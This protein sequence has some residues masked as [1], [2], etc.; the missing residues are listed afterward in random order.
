MELCPEPLWEE[1]CRADPTCTFYQTPSWLRIAAR[2]DQAEIA[3]LLFRP[4]GEP[5]C[6]PLLKKRRWGSDRYYSA[7]GTYAAT[8]CGKQ[9]GSEALASISRQLGDLNLHLVSSPFT[10]NPV[11]VGKANPS[12]VQV[13]DLTGLDS[14]NPMRDWGEDQRRR[15]R[16][17]QREGV[18]VRPAETPGEWDRYYE[19]YRL[20]LERWGGK[21]TVAYP[22][23]LFGDFRASLA[24]NPAMRLWVAEHQGEIGAGYLTFY[25]N[26]HVVPWHG[27]ADKRFFL[28]GV[29]QMLFHDMIADAIRR[30][31]RVFDLTG[32]GSLAKVEAFK[33]RFGTRTIEFASSRNRVGTARFLGRV[34][35]FLRKLA[36][37]GM[38][39][40]AVL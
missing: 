26:R 16:V 34:G 17:A 28:L 9:L 7:F 27:A 6:L 25:H 21:T 3:P 39:K 32:S 2:N 31:F 1:L 38:G 29:A 15:V 10:H 23:S 37:V 33:S 18:K 24:D 20:S 30:G 19:L 40:S 4:G 12:R 36:A 35:D 5:A 13:I 14:E 11:V 8:V 22:K